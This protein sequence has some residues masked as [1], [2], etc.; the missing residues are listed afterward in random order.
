M[1]RSRSCKVDAFK[2]K[3]QAHHLTLIYC[4][5][6][7]HSLTLNARY[8]TSSAT[9]EKGEQ[10]AT[11]GACWICLLDL[12]GGLRRGPPFF[13][14]NPI[15]RWGLWPRSGLGQCP[16]GQ[17]FLL[18]RGRHGRKTERE[19]QPGRATRVFL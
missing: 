15:S 10:S 11:C 18:G 8:G 7:G 9:D 14:S 5:N 17:R 12:D 19:N 3:I 1:G 4:P 13:H 6:P 16:P 2:S